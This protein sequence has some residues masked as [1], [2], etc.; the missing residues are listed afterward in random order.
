VCL[1]FALMICGSALAKERPYKGGACGEVIE[2]VYIAT[3]AADGVAFLK[4]KARAEGNFTH[5]GKAT[6]EL[7]WEVAAV[8]V[9]GHL[10]YLTT[11]AFEVTGANGDEMH[12]LF[13][14]WQSSLGGEARIQVTVQ[15]GS[16]KFRNARGIIPGR[17]EKDG[18][19][20]CY[21]LDGLL[22]Y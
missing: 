9:E 13:E 11:G 1:S 20:F 3:P 19:N 14:S 2:S 4:E 7:S 15:G 16:G 12:G 18:A 8:A 6:V 22:N 21:T 10:M 5:L 17:G